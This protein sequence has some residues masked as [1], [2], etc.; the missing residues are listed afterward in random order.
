MWTQPRPTGKEATFLTRSDG[1]SYAYESLG[2]LDLKKIRLFP[3]WLM[4]FC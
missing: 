3:G 2:S 4:I 1:D